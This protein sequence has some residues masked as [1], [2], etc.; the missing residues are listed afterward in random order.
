MTLNGKDVTARFTLDTASGEFRGLV[1]G[2][3]LG[4]NRLMATTKKPRSEAS[5]T[6]TNHAITGPILSGPHLTPFECSTEAS[7][8]GPAVD[9]NCSAPRKT[10]HFY[11]TTDSTFKTMRSGCATAGRRGHDDD[12]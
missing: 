4:A 1:E 5:L 12:H 11:R 7:G 10:W 8:L 9:A 2:L 3:L 6:V